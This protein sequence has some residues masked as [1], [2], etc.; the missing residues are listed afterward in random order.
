LN[1]I[2]IQAD[3]SVI[4]EMITALLKAKKPLVLTGPMMQSQAGRKVLASLEA[5]LGIPVIGMESPRGIGDPCLGAFSEVL[6]QSDCVLLLGKKLD[7]TLKFGKV[8][9]FH[10][11]CV[12]FQIDPEISRD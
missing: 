6:A 1:P 8:P 11:D 10:K 9:S 7:F 2:P 4:K 12:F 5:S 3:K